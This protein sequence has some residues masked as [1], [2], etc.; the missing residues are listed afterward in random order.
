EIENDAAGIGEVLDKN[1]LD[2]WGQCFA[3]ILRSG[4]VDKVALPAELLERQPKLCQR[5][6]IEVARSDELVARLHQGEE[7]QKLCG[8]PRGGSKCGA[9]AFEARDPLFKDRDRGVG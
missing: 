5:A 4:R 1:R 6:T 3:E 7:D 2:P 8:M 9:A